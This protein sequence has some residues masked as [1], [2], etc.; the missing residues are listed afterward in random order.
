[1]VG[2]NKKCRT[3]DYLCKH[4]KTGGLQTCDLKSKKE[5]YT[6]CGPK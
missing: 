4:L 3:S 5:K 1:M 2:K 6:F